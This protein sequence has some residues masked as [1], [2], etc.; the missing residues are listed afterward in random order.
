VPEVKA[1][2]LDAGKR[3][4]KAGW[5][6]EEISDVPFFEEAADLQVKM[7]LADG[8]QAMRDAAEREGDPGALNVLRFHEKT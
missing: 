5:S 7:W 3:L 2:V 4:D 8:Y 6:V 1:A